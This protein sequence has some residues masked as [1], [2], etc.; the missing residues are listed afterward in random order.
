LGD[1]VDD[2]GGGAVSKVDRRETSVSCV[3]NVDVCAIG[4]DGKTHVLARPEEGVSQSNEKT[5]I[6]I[7]YPRS[8]T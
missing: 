3:A 5:R 4:R 8:Q 1:V 7:Q 2:D 6:D